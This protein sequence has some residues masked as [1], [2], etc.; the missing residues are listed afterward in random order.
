MTS[1]AEQ[2]EE[3]DGMRNENKRMA[4]KRRMGKNRESKLSQWEENRESKLSQ[5]EENRESKL[6]H[7]LLHNRRQP[8]HLTHSEHEAELRQNA[9][10]TEILSESTCR[11]TFF[12]IAASLSTFLRYMS[13]TNAK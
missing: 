8:L 5:W 6:S 9:K 4:H 3:H 11:I 7:Y 10:E 13:L 2:N 12:T 1:R